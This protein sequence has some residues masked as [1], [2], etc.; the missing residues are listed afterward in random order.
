MRAGLKA[1]EARGHQGGCKL[2]VTADKRAR[3]RTHLASGLTVHD[4]PLRVKVG[5]TALYRALAALPSGSESA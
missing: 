5:K 1:A 4:E 2:A 3:V